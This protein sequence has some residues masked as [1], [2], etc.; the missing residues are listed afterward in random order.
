MNTDRARQCEIVEREF[1]S[2]EN[3]IDKKI[4]E[5]KP[6]EAMQF[7]MKL[8]GSYV[9]ADALGLINDREAAMSRIG[10]WPERI[11]GLR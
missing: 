8:Y 7:Y 1:Q 3:L 2:W 6:D 5:N 11:Y 9:M 4:R 10:D